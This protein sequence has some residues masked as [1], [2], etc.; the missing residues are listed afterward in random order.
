MPPVPVVPDSLAALLS[1]L[2]PCFTAPTYDIFC[3]LLVGFISQVG[4]RTVC[5]M[6]QAAGLAGVFHHSRAHGFFAAARWSP[7]ELGLRLAELLIAKLTPAGE[8]LR[9][10]LDDTLFH[11]SGRKVFGAYL[12]HDPHAGAGPRLGFGNCWVVLGLLVHL[13]CLA[14]PLFLP[15]LFRLYRPSRPEAPRPSR[16]QLGRELLDLTAARF[17]QRRI[18]LLADAAYA[19]RAFRELPEE[20]TL[21][22]R[23]RRDAALYAPAPPRSGRCG[24][25]R[26]KGARLPTLAAAAGAPGAAW[27]EVTLSRY[28]KRSTARLMVID[29]L[30]YG[31]L[32]EQPVRVVLV[33][34]LKRAKGFDVALVTT[35]VKAPPE[36]AVA[37]YAERW[38]IEV[39]FQDAKQ[40]L[41]VGEARSRSQQAVLRT[42]PFGLLCQSLT[43]AWYALNGE[44]EEDVR[45]R[46][47]SAPWYRQKSQ[48]AFAD[49]LVALR[50]EMSSAEYTQGL[51]RE[52]R[53]AEITHPSAHSARSAA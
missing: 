20:V 30:W 35:D 22:M 47:L 15:L 44:A 39:S 36:Q 24:R 26:K 23:L 10:A 41:G 49:M 33:R 52:G 9:F 12:H 38:A 18:E 3:W 31:V 34:E 4:E 2:R 7:D 29:C 48:P 37:R 16:P 50:R 1:L 8:P 27:R 21:T 14:R 11:R 6:W 40:V 5:G 43:V 25:P 19:C 32:G 13:P 46:R 45:R 42:V 17:P 53:S 51:P 28:G